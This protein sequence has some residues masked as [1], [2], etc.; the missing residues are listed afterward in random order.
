MSGLVS[1]VIVRGSSSKMAKPVSNRTVLGQRDVIRGLL[2]EGSK[3]SENFGQCSR[4]MVNKKSFLCWTIRRVPFPRLKIELLPPPSPKSDYDVFQP[5][6]KPCV[7]G[8]SPVMKLRRPSKRI[9]D[10][11]RKLSSHLV[12]EGWQ[13]STPYAL[14]GGGGGGQ[15]FF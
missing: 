8:D 14:K 12:S 4:K 9:F 15:G 7:D 13:T 5:L 10:H 3:I 1:V 6:K 11:N 2:S